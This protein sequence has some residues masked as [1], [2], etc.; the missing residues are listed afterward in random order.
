MG[1]ANKAAPNKHARLA[2]SSLNIGFSKLDLSNNHQSI[3]KTFCLN[4]KHICEFIQSFD[5][6]LSG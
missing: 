5:N 2:K 6:I 4:I 1:A 3:L